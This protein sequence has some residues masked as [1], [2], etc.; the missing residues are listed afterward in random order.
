MSFGKIDM[1]RSG[2]PV[3][4]AAA[5]MVS[6]RTT[7]A[8][9]PPRGRRR[10]LHGGEQGPRG[11]S[12]AEPCGHFTSSLESR[13]PPH[14]KP[15]TGTCARSTAASGGLS[16]PGRA[17]S[18]TTAST[19]SAKAGIRTPTPTSRRRAGSSQRAGRRAP[20][21]PDRTV[22]RGQQRSRSSLTQRQVAAIPAG[23]RPTRHDRGEASQ[24]RGAGST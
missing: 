12:Q 3:R 15:F 22:N 1:R 9:S 23:Q 4:A 19:T 20:C 7:N 11:S 18:T 24:A 6:E 8:A 21:V 17:W 10:C 5:A 2:S 16:D 14:A 13:T